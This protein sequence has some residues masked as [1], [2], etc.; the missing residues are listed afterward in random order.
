MIVSRSVSFR[1]FMSQD[2]ENSPLA[3]SWITFSECYKRDNLKK[4][5]DRKLSSAKMRMLRWARG[6]TRLDHI[7]NDDIGKKAYVKPNET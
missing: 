4:K 5:D 6:K 2:V 3:A 7:R 1:D